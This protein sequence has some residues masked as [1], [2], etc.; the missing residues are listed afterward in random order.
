MLFVTDFHDAHTSECLYGL[1]TPGTS[2]SF[3]L[4][5]RSVSVV[6]TFFP[7]WDS[8]ILPGLVR[9]NKHPWFIGLC[10][11]STFCQSCKCKIKHRIITQTLS[12]KE[13]CLTR[14]GRWLL[15]PRWNWKKPTIIKVNCLSL[16]L[17]CFSDS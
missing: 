10:L 7:V 11:F 4:Q 2:A 5:S 14:R 13:Y 16:E 6:E 9:E 15:S 12:K 8:C 17:F 1:V 3:S